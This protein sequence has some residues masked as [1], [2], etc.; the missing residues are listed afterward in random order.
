MMKKIKIVV[1]AKKTIQVSGYNPYQTG[2][3]VYEDKRRKRS[4]HKQELRRMVDS[5]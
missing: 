2:H 5:Y 3:G 4:Y 1:P